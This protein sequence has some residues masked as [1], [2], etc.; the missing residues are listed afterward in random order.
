MPRVVNP[1]FSPQRMPGTPDPGPST[2]YFIV[3]DGGSGAVL[4]QNHA[5]EAISPASLT[6][7]MT[8]VLA[9]E[10]GGPNDRVK[11]DVDAAEFEGSAVM[12]LK[13][14]ME[15]T[16]QDLLYGLMLSSGNDAAVAI[17]R[18]VAGSTEAFVSQM[19]A[20]AAWLGLGATHFVN[21]HGFDVEGHY[22][23]PADMVTLARYA[24]QY[25]VF[26]QVVA[27]RT[28]EVRASTGSYTLRNVN[29]LL[30]A[31]PGADGVK[32]GDTPMA[33]RSLVGTA[34]QNGRRIYVAFMRSSGGAVYDGMLLLDWAFNS[35]LWPSRSVLPD[36]K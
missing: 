35:H 7:I 19:N 30:S 28:Y 20:K 33:G 11:V 17:A 31:Y 12:G 16:F 4:F 9:I 18:H 36:R 32:T 23:S 24:M 26:R 6:K 29:D 13:R 5:Y 3:V 1:G 8:A 21:P 25:A 22:S 10:H 34:V 2:S 14:G 27:T 15:V